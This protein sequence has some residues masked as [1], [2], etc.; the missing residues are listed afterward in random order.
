[1]KK[2]VLLRG[3]MASGKSTFIKDNHLEDY[4]LSS[5]NIRLMFNSLEMTINYSDA[6]PQFNNKKIWNLLYQILEERMK[7][8][9]FTIVDAMHIYTDDL[10]I[11]KKLAEKYRYRLYIVDF[12]DVSYEELIERNNN[13]ESKKKVP[14][15]AI[16][17]VYNAL[18]K[19]KKPKDFIIIKPNEF[20]SILNNKPKNVDQYNNIHIFGDI[21]GCFNTLKKYFDDSPIKEND[22]YIFVG[23]YFDRGLE[24]VKTFEFLKSLLDRK[25]FIFLTGNHEDRLYKYACDDEYTLD[26]SIMKTIE[27]MK[28]IKKSEIRGFIKRLSQISYIQFRNKEYIITHGGIPYFPDKPLDF[29]SSNSFIYGIDKHEVDIDK[30][31]NDFMINQD[32]KIYQIHG[33]RN[34][35]KIEYNKYPYSYNLDGNIETGGFLRVLNLNDDGT[36]SITEIKNDIYDSKILE[37]E[38]VFSLLEDLRK[39][40][41]IFEKKL[42]N[43]ISS[44][45]FTNEAF[46]DYVWNNITTQA[47]GLFI[48]TNDY[49]IVARS[50]NKFFNLDERHETK[51]E[52]L[53]ERLAFPV[54]F[55][56]KYN[57]FLGILS[58]YNDELLFATKSELNGVY[59]EYFKNIFYEIYSKE[60]INNIKKRLKE[61][62]TSMIFEVIDCINDKHIIEYQENHLVLLDEIY[63][64]VNYKKVGYDN[65]KSFADSNNIQIKEKVYVANNIKEFEDIYKNISEYDYKLNNNHIEGF[66]IEDKKGFMVKY[67]TE[68]YKKWKYLRSKMENAILKNDFK[69]KSNDEIDNKFMM[70]LEN[71][72]KNK[73]IDI[74]S[75]TIIDERN[76]FEKTSN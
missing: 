70:F 37:K 76:C 28:D 59:N 1:M 40:K 67:K 34:P 74:S 19:E 7:K 50:Y 69:I 15:E 3:A 75:I 10:S 11:Y 63:N 20:F 14:N 17:R 45:N 26:Y 21:H 68:Y 6:I 47:R 16:K 27:E 39:S 12:T 4:T 57:G 46:Y 35:L 65:L 31:Y 49:L 64:I 24:N 53:K 61:N 72:Y 9:E 32:K 43:N 30:I 41:Y 2:L 60:Q 18:K 51:Y 55:Y 25:N 62:E 38:K 44:F 56:L 54:N 58:L 33:H 71:K 29:Y 5:D 52:V 48:D 36:T 42:D 13:R 23:D 73:N 22:L 66:V 8:G